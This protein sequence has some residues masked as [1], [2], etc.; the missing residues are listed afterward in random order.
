MQKKL[1]SVCCLGYNHEQF[2][3][4]NINAVLSSKYENIEII[5]V[6]DGSSDNSQSVLRRIAENC[7]YPIKLIFQ[8]NTGSPAKNFNR[9]I[10]NASGEFIT[11]ISLDDFFNMPEIDNSLLLMNENPKIGFIT[12]TNFDIID[13]DGKFVENRKL[14]V[15]QRTDSTAEQMLE[16]EYS[17]FESFWLQGTVFR[18]EIIDAVHGFDGD[19]LAD[20]IILRTKVLRFIQE[21]KDYSFILS[22]KK[23]FFYR[24]HGNNISGNTIRQVKSVAQYLNR[25]WPERENPKIFNDWVSYANKVYDIPNLK[26]LWIQEKRLINALA[27]E[28]VI[29]PLIEKVWSAVNAFHKE[30]LTARLYFDTGSGFSEEDCIKETYDSNSNTSIEF[31]IPKTDLKIQALRFD[32]V[33][34]SGCMEV[35]NLKIIKKDESEMSIDL[36][37]IQLNSELKLENKYFF[38]TCDPMLIFSLNDYSDVYAVKVEFEWFSNAVLHDVLAQLLNQKREEINALYN[39]FS[40]K[41]SKPIRIV[42][43]LVR[44]LLLLK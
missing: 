24:L 18:K 39:S 28:S 12:S 13:G 31:K 8:E 14:P 22:D 20:D 11:F 30:H 40:W 4:A 36:N 6:D 16:F 26:S 10:E 27:D 41:I 19:M 32:P 34:E 9:S 15:Y 44:R 35:R 38:K 7:R 25:Y 29:E 17:R 5:V 21:N 37:N 42:G 2:I 43:K 23:S 1:L 3:E 33:E